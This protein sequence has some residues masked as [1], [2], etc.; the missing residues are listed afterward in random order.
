MFGAG[1][2]LLARAMF[3]ALP[4]ATGQAGAPLSC[5]NH[6]DR[7]AAARLARS[8]LDGL[9]LLDRSHDR[10]VDKMPENTQYLGL[11]AALFPA[12][13]LI[14]CRRD[15]RDV[16]LSI[17]LTE[18]GQLRWACDVEDIAGRIDDY[19]RLIDHWRCVLP[20]PILEV[21]YEE[22]VANP[23]NA[24]RKLVDWCGLEWDPA[25]LAFYKT[26]RAVRTPSTAAVR[27]PVY[28]TSVARWKNYERRLARLFAKLKCDPRSRWSY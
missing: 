11:I 9:D 1:E 14:H 20:S 22:I 26:Q 8:Y 28:S 19:R 10:V 3:E 16:A 23:E 27:Q 18:F 7:R 13:T 21:D 12:A 15:V 2:L 25:C 17:W 4:R 5:L 24:A 6:I